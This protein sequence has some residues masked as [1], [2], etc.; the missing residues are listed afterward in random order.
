MIAVDVMGGDYAPKAILDGSI[1]AA[2]EGIPILLVGP[3]NVVLNYLNDLN[4]SWRDLPIEIQDS[5]EV[6][7]MGE[8]PVKS[9]LEKKKSSLVLAVQAVKSGKCSAVVSAGNSGALM[10]AANFV[11]GRA[12]GIERSPIAGFLP[13]ISKSVLCLD[14]GA[15]VDCKSFYFEQFANLGVSYLESKSLVVNPRV[16]LLSNGTE[17]GKGSSL[18]K[19]AFKLLSRSKLNF[20]GNVEPKDIVENRAD[21]VVCDG[22]AGNILLKS[23]ESMFHMLKELYFKRLSGFQKDESLSLFGECFWG[24]FAQAADWTKQG[25]AFLLGINGS[26]VVAHGCSNSVAVKNAI[27]LA[28]SVSK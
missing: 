6:I 14:L 16:G 19:E 13:G 28:A 7:G 15:N 21:I 2:I 3:Q 22:F 17:P 1:K 5:S 8:D 9:V 24:D 4:F 27:L 23:F 18:V 26:V 20:V 12:E 10:A 25:G 11:L